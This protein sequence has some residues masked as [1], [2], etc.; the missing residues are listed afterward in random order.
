[1]VLTR[2]MTRK[3]IEN[4]NVNKDIYRQPTTDYI[5]GYKLVFV[6]PTSIIHGPKTDTSF[7]IV[8]LLIPNSAKTNLERQ[9]VNKKYAKYRTE[10]AKVVY[11]KSIIGKT[12][13]R[14]AYSVLKPGGYYTSGKYI[15]CN[16]WNDN[17]EEVCTNGIHFYLSK[18][19]VISLYLTITNNN[20]N[21][22][23]E[24]ILNTVTYPNMSYI[25][26]DD[27]GKIEYKVYFNKK[28][29]LYKIKSY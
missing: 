19:S 29:N 14:R 8:K 17:I 16:K 6:E 13:Y 10:Y 20:I 9:V 22:G 18:R 27:D 5:I 12:L 23:I 21:K 24:G 11:I 26:V 28:G 2:S 4:T 25:H 15:H 1:M 7:G 3:L